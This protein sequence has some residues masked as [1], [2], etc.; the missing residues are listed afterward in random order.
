[1]TVIDHSLFRTLQLPGLPHPTLAGPEHGLKT[2]EV[3]LETLAPGAGHQVHHHECEEVFV[4]LS[5]SGRLTIAPPKAT[6]LISWSPRNC[7]EAQTWR[8]QGDW[9]IF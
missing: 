7:R 3:W 1:M 6:G 4:G 8:G 2:L 9:C 5:G